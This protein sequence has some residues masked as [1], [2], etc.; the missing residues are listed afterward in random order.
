MAAVL[1]GGLFR[2]FLNTSIKAVAYLAQWCTFEQDTKNK[3]S[4]HVTQ[5]EVHHCR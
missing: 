5:S 2:V 1:N 4:R 3:N